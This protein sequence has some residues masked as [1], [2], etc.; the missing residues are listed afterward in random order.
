MHISVRRRVRTTV[1]KNRQPRSL[2][3]NDR[4]RAAKQFF[5]EHATY[6]LN[7]AQSTTHDG[8]TVDTVSHGLVIFEQFKQ[9]LHR[10]FLIQGSGPVH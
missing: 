5:A 3:V 7:I 10:I 6:I 2:T 1:I 9:A 4:Q 8:C